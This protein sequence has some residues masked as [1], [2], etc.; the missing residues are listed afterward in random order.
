MCWCS[1]GK[2]K[3]RVHYSPSSRRGEQAHAYLAAQMRAIG[4]TDLLDGRIDVLASMFHACDV[5]RN[6]C[7]DAHEYQH[8]RK[9]LQQLATL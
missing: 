4:S 6:R 3:V 8:E 2:L 9:R 7:K 1:G 5:P